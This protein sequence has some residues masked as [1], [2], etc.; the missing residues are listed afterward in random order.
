MRLAQVVGISRQVAETS[1]RLRKISL[2]AELLT[3]LTP[4]E[5]EIAVAWLSGSTRQGKKGVGYAVLRDAGA[6]AAAEPSLEILETDHLLDALSKVKGRGSEQ[7]KRAQLRS[8]MERATA[9][10]Q[11]FLNDLLIG[12]L[13]QGALEGIMLEAVARASGVP[14]P[15]VRR[16][17]MMAGDMPRVA[18]ALQE[19]GTKALADFDV[20]LFRPVHP[21][22]AQPAPDTDE[23]LSEMGEAALEYKLDGARIQAHRRGDEVRVYTRA[24]NE[25][26]ETVPEVVE[27]VR[28]M[29]VQQVILD[30]EVIGFAASGRPQPFQ[31]TMRRFGRKLDVDRLRGEIPLTPVWFD[32][33]YRDGESLIDLPQRDRF[34]VLQTVAAPENLVHHILTSDREVAGHFLRDALDAGHEGIL[35]KNPNAP[36][37]A[38]ARGQNWLK[39]KKAHTLDLV[40]LAAEWGSGRRKGYLSNLHLGARDTEKGGFA[41]LGKTFKGLTDEMLRWQTEELLKLETHRDSYTVYVEPKIVVE[42]AYSDLQVSP[43]YVSGLA[44]RFARVKRYRMDKTA[45]EADTFETVK[46][47]ASFRT[48]GCH[49]RSRERLEVQRFSQRP[50]RCADLLLQHHDRVDQLLGA[51]RAARA[52]KR[53]PE[54]PG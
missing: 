18:R 5:V 3:R 37:E 51:R 50:M 26:T 6:A 28:A 38:G 44:L 16:A 8:L 35:A 17:A 49:H 11:R 27:A 24:L 22:L 31:V 39:I 4:E 34:R 7:E 30:G 25:V 42:I 45:E 46:K 15:A 2:I 29:P 52:R 10:E 32:I 14:L 13:R 21:M 47:L 36:Y 48:A 12:N 1:G 40:I 33:L 54:S 23:A 19:N 53:P 43:R 20:Q 41:M 9:D